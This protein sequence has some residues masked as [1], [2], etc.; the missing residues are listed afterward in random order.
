MTSKRWNDVITTLFL[1]PML[2]PQKNSNIN[3]INSM[4]YSKVFRCEKVQNC[5]PPDLETT[6]FN[7]CLWLQMKS[8]FSLFSLV[9]PIYPQPAK[10]RKKNVEECIFDY[11]ASHIKCLFSINSL[12]QCYFLAI[13]P[14]GSE[15]ET[16]N[17]REPK[18]TEIKLNWTTLYNSKSSLFE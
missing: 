13:L 2:Y 9:N 7:T 3:E 11:M 18:S 6:C 16:T 10:L 8:F 4:V 12:L 15:I 14:A 17:M 5:S 1:H